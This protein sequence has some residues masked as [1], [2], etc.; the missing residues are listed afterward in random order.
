MSALEP[1]SG[2]LGKEYAKDAR[3]IV[4][5]EEMNYPERNVALRAELADP[6][7][8]GHERRTRR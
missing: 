5:P 3:T 6:R 4:R 2:L 7:R 8:R 1:S